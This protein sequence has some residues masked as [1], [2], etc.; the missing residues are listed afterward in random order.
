MISNLIASYTGRVYLPFSV[1]VTGRIFLE[2]MKLF[3]L[4]SFSSIPA[5]TLQQLSVILKENSTCLIIYGDRSS[6]P[7]HV[8]VVLRHS[9]KLRQCGV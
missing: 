6:R 5:F 7:T 3:P 2:I 1:H 8:P 4:A 9:V